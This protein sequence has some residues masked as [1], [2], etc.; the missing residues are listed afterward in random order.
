MNQFNTAEKEAKERIAANEIALK[1][2]VNGQTTAS[3]IKY[4]VI[5]EGTG[6]LNLCKTYI[7][8]AISNITI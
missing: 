1:E 6:M 8:N 3:G 4:I 7:V 5:K 2:F